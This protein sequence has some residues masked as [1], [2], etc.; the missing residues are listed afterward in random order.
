MT[1]SP[2]RRDAG[3]E[4]A[5]T[6][7]AAARDG[8][9]PPSGTDTAHYIEEMARELSHLA[10]SSKLDLLAYLLDMV[11]LEARKNTG[12]ISGPR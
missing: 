2:D 1:K 8:G 9:F 6:A 11:R 3:K 5:G 4:A 12:R 10:R 7:A